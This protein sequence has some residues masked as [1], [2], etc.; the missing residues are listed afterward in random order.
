MTPDIYNA[1]L[2]IAQR[3]HG[4]AFPPSKE[5]V[6]YLEE[7]I[8]RYQEIATEALKAEGWEA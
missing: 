1:L 6:T 7:V 8:E 4:I 5:Y 3:Q 2:R